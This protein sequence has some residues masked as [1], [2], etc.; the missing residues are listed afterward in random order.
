MCLGVTW[1][2]ERVIWAIKNSLPCYGGI[3]TTNHPWSLKRG[4]KTDATGMTYEDGLIP[5][6]MFQESRVFAK[7]R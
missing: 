4:E 1:P 6:T 3:P 7:K 2:H 5:C